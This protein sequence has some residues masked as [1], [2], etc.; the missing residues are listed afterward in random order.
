[1]FTNRGLMDYRQSLIRTVL[2]YMHQ[3]GESSIILWN[4]NQM[5]EDEIYNGPVDIKYTD[6]PTR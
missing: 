1:M 2:I 4:K 5:K 6:K 3:D